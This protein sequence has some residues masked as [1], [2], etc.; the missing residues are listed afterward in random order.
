[1]KR[2]NILHLRSLSDSLIN[3]FMYNMNPEF[4]NEYSRRS[5]IRQKINQITEYLI[6]KYHKERI[7]QK[8]ECVPEFL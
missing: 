1:M 4:I 7:S 2:N 3:I 6:L 5:V 8:R